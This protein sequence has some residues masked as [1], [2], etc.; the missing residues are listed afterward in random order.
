MVGKGFSWVESSVLPVGGNASYSFAN[1]QRVDM[2][3]TFVGLD[4]FEI[5]H[6]AHDGIFVHDA[7]GAE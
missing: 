7:V 1:D 4:G 6:V 3:C 2:I 5:A